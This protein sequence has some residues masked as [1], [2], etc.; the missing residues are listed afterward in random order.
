VPF[1]LDTNVVSEARKAE[2]DP[3]VTRWLQTSG[4]EGSYLS[5]LVIGEIR[6]G[7][8]RLAR[9][10]RVQAAVIE[11]W[12]ATIKRDF[13]GRVVPITLDIAEEW[14]RLNALD[15]IPAADGLMAATAL[16]NNWTFATRNTKDLERTGVPLVNP[17][18]P[19]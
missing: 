5:V 12:L 19:A 3:N 16:V 18:D 10:D 8:Q 1:L 11:D 14:G 2:P 6:Q 17:F 9:R 15:P 4:R 7:I 13:A